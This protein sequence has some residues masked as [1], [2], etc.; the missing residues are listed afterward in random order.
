MVLLFYVQEHP[1][2][3]PAVVLISKH[4]RS[5]GHGLKSHRTDWEKPGIELATAGL[6][7]IGL[8]VSFSSLNRKCSV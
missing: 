4:H 5:R 2:T 3:K 8:A 6:Q 1:K 7:G